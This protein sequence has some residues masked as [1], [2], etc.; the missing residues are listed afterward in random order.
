MKLILWPWHDLALTLCWWE[1]ITQWLLS[2]LAP[3][4]SDNL[5]CNS[6]IETLKNGLDCSSNYSNYINSRIRTV[7]ADCLLD[8]D[9]GWHLH[10][11]KVSLKSRKFPVWQ[12][13]EN[14]HV[15][16][17]IGIFIY[18][19]DLQSWQWRVVNNNNF[20]IKEFFLVIEPFQ[21]YWTNLKQTWHKPSLGEGDKGIQGFFSFFLK[22]RA[23]RC[24]REDNSDTVNMHLQ[25]FRTKEGPYK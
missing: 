22:W 18:S 6:W 7:A 14:Q 15:Y 11:A 8:M 2:S 1:T 10:V 16:L 9:Q 13:P 4:I 21:N 12:R 20:F 3:V 5:L 19:L 24:P 23:S 25:L 17:Y